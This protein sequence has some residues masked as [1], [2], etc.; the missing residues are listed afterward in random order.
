MAVATRMGFRFRLASFFVA[1]LVAVQ[2]LTAFLA[3]DVT[4]QQLIAEGQRR[5]D[6]AA[7]AFGRQLDDLSTR[8]AAGVQVLA[9]DFALRSAIAERDQDTVR[10]ALRNHGRRVGATQML[11][12][13]VDGRIETDTL[14][15]FAPQSPFPYTDLLE[16]ALQQPASAVVAWD[17]RAYWMVVVPVFAP[18]LVGFIAAAIPVDDRLLLHLQQQSALPRSVELATRDAGGHWHV[19]ARGSDRVALTGPLTT[20]GGALPTTPSVVRVGAR[21]YVV[22]SIT[23]SRS[24]Q[25]TPVTAVLGYSVDEALSPYRSVAV[26]WAGLLV[27]GLLVGLAAAWLIAR[28]VSRPVEQ[29]A[30]TARRIEAGDYDA[31]PTIAGGDEIGE[32]AAAF[33]HMAQSIRER[34]TRIR[35]QADHDQ[36]TGLDNRSAAE[37]SIQRQLTLHPERAAALLMV[38]LGRL[39]EIVKTMGHVVSDRVMRECGERL[40]ATAGDDGIA[41]ATDAHFAIF[42]PA[43]DAAA[44]S[45]AAGRVVAALAAPYHESDISLDLAPAVG[46]ALAPFHGSEA[47]AL[48]RHAEVALIT[49]LGTEEPVAIYDPA[50][51]PH[52]PERLSLMGDLRQ[53]L[54]QGRIDMH[55]QPKLNLADGSIDGAE[56]LARWQHPVHGAIA[57]DAFIGLAEET[58]NI[59]RLTRWALD[60][61]IAQAG[62]WR[63]GGHSIRVSIN[64]S[65]RDLDDVELPRRVADLLAGHDLAPQAIA[66]EITESAI[67][68]KPDAAIG[69]LRQLAEQGIELAIDDFGVGQSSFAYLRRLPVRELKIDKM[70]ITH[71]ASQPED[72]VIVRSIVELGH[73]LGCRVTAEGVE[74][75]DALAYLADI[76]CDHA[77]GYLIARALPER[78]FERFLAAAQWPR[79]A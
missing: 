24:H 15:H 8:V 49:A 40:C 4:R 66:L 55:Y 58:G 45:D 64:L 20:G 37:M 46:I 72:R 3:Y 61:G 71:L 34:E 33:I 23:L 74:D 11:L 17:G 39:P 53:A 48:L 10:S 77:Q 69:V 12:V 67:M 47:G 2:G 36:L 76:G 54:E 75:A 73:Q 52:R 51:D 19:I 65:A 25:S 59:R 41:R 38:G 63:T 28:S 70:F 18:N 57:P 21:E 29:L 56:A 50:V 26:A 44:A 78:E 1:T 13:D 60:C 9:L 35:Y 14:E 62:R 30:A 6:V 79:R 68:G 42:L 43:A 32:L 5:L 27:F 31:L 16:G 7:T 22:Q